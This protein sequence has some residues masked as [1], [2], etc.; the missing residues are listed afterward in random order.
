MN[1][2]RSVRFETKTKEEVEEMINSLKSIFEIEN[3]VYKT[4]E[5]RNKK[6]FYTYLRIKKLS[7]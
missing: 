5:H 6:G 7:T 1:E 3:D 2:F 4:Y